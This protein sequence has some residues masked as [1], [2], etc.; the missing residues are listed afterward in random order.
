LKQEGA[1]YLVIN[2]INKTK[3]VKHLVNEILKIKEKT[4][5]KQSTL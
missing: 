3:G 5:P 2:P 4:E 1:E